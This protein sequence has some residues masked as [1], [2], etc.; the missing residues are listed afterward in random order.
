MNDNFNL[1]VG[2]IKSNG[3]NVHGIELISE[4]E[5]VDSYGDTKSLYPLYS[6]TK[7]ILALAVGIAW[8]RGVFNLDEAVTKYIPA[9]IIEGMS[10]CQKKLFDKVTIRRL[11]TMSVKGFA[12]RPEG[13][14]YLKFALDSSID[15]DVDCFEYSN[16]SAY[17]VGVA[18]TFVVGDV[19][20]F[21]EKELLLPL[22][23]TSYNYERCPDGFFYGAS[24]MFMS[25]SDLSR[26]GL[27]VS[28]HGIYDGKRILS[29]EYIQEMT[30][31]YRRTEHNGY[32]LLTWIND[33]CCYFKGKNEQRC[34]ISFCENKVISYLSEIEGNNGE[35]DACVQEL[36]I[37]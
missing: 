34:F 37:K 15:P 28:N 32:G 1:L 11:M 13:D 21:I 31:V 36:L 22:G 26:L 23:I 8:D 25:V 27:L 2:R 30:K 16:I 10:E 12:F 9:S 5:L 35:L 29:D 18:L 20:E 19:G 33:K 7:T 24:K 14:S 6:A 17:L 3:W 4:G